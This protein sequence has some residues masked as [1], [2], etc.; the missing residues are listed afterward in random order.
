V[1]AFAGHLDMVRLLIE[2]GGDPTAPANDH[3]PGQFLPPDRTPIGWARYNR[4]HH[5]AAYLSSITS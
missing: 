1:A 3:T 2:L 5:V 4:H